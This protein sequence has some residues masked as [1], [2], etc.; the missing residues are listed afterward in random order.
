MYLV[1]AFFSVRSG[2]TFSKNNELA[3]KNWIRKKY[4]FD[5]NLFTNAQLNGQRNSGSLAPSDVNKLPI[6]EP[7]FVNVFFVFCVSFK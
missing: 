5:T 1:H 2:E 4:E 3:N 6:T 7:E